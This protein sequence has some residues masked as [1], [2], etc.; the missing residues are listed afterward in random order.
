MK[1][2]TNYNLNKPDYT[3]GADIPAHYNENMDKIDEELKANSSRTADLEQKVNEPEYLE[4]TSNSNI[5]SL[6]SNVEK[7]QINVVKIKAITTVNPFCI[8]LLKDGKEVVLKYINVQL[9]PGEIYEGKLSVPNFVS[10]DTIEVDSNSQMEITYQIPTNIASNVDGLN[11][12]MS[13]L[14]SNMPHQAKDITNN[15][16]YKFGLQI[17]NGKPQIICEEVE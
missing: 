8:K 11:S 5:I 9:N 14:T 4:I 7:G 13:K 2:T 3:D 16:T 12:E 10:A 6:D 1:Y 17:Q 15:K